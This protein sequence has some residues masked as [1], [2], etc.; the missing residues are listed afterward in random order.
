MP[1]A[2]AISNT[3]TCL[4]SNTILCNFS[5]VSG[6]VVVFGRPS[7]SFLSNV[8]PHLNSTVYFLMVEIEQSSLKY[9]SNLDELHLLESHLFSPYPRIRIV[10]QI[11]F[12]CIANIRGMINV[13]TYYNSI[14]ICILTL[15]VKML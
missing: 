13:N 15:F 14:S 5:L 11:I 7:G 9:L 8:R 1:M 3:F 2:S 12:L 4:S 6:V 10:V